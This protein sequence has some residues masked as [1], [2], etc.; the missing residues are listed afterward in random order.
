MKTEA[1]IV[2]S[3]K[4][5]QDEAS[6]AAENAVMTLQDQYGFDNVTTEFVEAHQ[7]EYLMWFESS[8]EA[9]IE[10]KFYR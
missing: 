1:Q 9:L 10:S 5:T 2:E 8:I 3:Y 7:A 4:A 6:A